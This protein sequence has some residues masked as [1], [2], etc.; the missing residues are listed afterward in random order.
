MMFDVI[1]L[2]IGRSIVCG[3]TF[4]VVVG[5]VIAVVGLAIG[6]RGHKG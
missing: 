6:M 5:S 2:Y 4:V 3:L 1:C